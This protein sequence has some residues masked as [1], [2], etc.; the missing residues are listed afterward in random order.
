MPG[1]IT[2]QNDGAG[3]FT[4]TMDPAAYYGVAAQNY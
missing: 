4:L 2:A 3:V 1:A